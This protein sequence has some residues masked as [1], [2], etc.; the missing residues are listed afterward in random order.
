MSIVPFYFLN[1]LVLAVALVAT[2]AGQL[3]QERAKLAMDEKVES[4]KEL[5]RQ[6]V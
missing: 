6:L 2:V 4:E 3:G 5:A 1:V